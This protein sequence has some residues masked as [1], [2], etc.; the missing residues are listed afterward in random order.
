MLRYSLD[1]DREADAVEN[2]VRKV[3]AEGYR[4]GDIMSEG[5]RQVSTTEMGLSDRGAYLRTA[6]KEVSV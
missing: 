2:A 3:L 6:Y 4:T 1:L 5:C